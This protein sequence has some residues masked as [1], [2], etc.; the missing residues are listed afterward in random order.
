MLR[1]VE[2]NNLR[3]MDELIFLSDKAKNDDDAISALGEQQACLPAKAGL[4]NE[5]WWKKNKFNDVAFFAKVL[6]IKEKRYPSW[7]RAPFFVLL[8]KKEKPKFLSRSL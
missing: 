6:I 3:K 8:N 1:D 4:F 7:E 5:V 2:I